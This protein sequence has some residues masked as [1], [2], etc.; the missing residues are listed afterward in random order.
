[1]VLGQWE[2]HGSVKTTTWNQPK[3]PRPICTLF[4]VSSDGVYPA[5]I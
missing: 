5:A 4:A 1:L 2:R 3:V